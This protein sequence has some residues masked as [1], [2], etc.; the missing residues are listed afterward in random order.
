MKRI[1]YGLLSRIPRSLPVG[2]T[3]FD[4]W[5]T[6]LIS[7]GGKYADEDSLRFALASILIHADAKHGALPDKY[8]TDRL[9]KSAANQVASQVFQDIKAKQAAELA[10]K[11]AEATAQL[12]E[13]SNET[14]KTT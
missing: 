12:A 5:A 2:A 7:Q 3:E 4:T 1:V 9:R 13:A 14:P 11:Q 6:R 10:A 8:F